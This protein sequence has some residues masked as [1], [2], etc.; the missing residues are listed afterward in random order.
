VLVPRYQFATGTLPGGGA[1]AI[2]G[3]LPPEQWIWDPAPA[4]MPTK[5]EESFSLVNDANPL[6]VVI[7]DQAGG[8]ITRFEVPRALNVPGKSVN[9]LPRCRRDR[10]PS[11][12]DTLGGLATV[13]RSSCSQRRPLQRAGRAAPGPPDPG[14]MP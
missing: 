4:V 5:A 6:A 14:S 12:H 11:L 3:N 10:R 8:E 9:R 1:V 2:Y 13:A 7:K